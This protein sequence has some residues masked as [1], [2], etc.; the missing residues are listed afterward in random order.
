ML[1]ENLNY[2]EGIGVE[3]SYDRAFKLYEAAAQQG[4]AD[5][6][7]NLA[8]MYL[9]GESVPENMSLAKHWFEIAAAQGVQCWRNAYNINLKICVILFS[10]WM[11]LRIILNN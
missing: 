1:L 5:A 6:A 10:Q 11:I 2:F 4:H 3:E 7:N 9:N 8:D